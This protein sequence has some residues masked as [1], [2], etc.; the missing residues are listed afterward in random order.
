MHSAA[1]TNS[2]VYNDVHQLSIIDRQ[3]REL[4]VTNCQPGTHNYRPVTVRQAHTSTSH[5]Q[6]ETRFINQSLSHR[7][8]HYQP[9]TV[10][11]KHALLTSHR[12]TETRII[13]QLTVSQKH[14]LSTSHYQ[15]GTHIINQSLSDRHTHY[16]PVTVRHKHTLSTSHC[17]ADTHNFTYQQL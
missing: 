17:Q 15:T 1:L 9:V 13:N 12:Q 14:A 4:S 8:T 6:T 10:R 5:C 7:H 3:D 11:H 2:Y 16:Q